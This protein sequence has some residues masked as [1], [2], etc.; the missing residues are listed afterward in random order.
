MSIDRTKTEPTGNRS[1]AAAGPGRY[2][3]FALADD[4]FAFEVPRVR[5]I[6]SWADVEAVPDTPDYLLGV[7]GLQ[8]ARLPIVDLRR[9]LALQSIPPDPR[10]LVVVLRFV[11]NGVSLPVGFT[12]DSSLGAH[13]LVNEITSPSPE[14]H[15]PVSPDF[16][17]GMSMLND[18]QVI[19]LETDRLIDFSVLASEA[20]TRLPDSRRVH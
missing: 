17:R 7:T 5:Q 1:G 16:V 2:L 6:R 14:Q 11:C 13:E 4:Y 15:S 12:V 18:Q 3:I 20:T 19:L 10:T 8:G 9:R